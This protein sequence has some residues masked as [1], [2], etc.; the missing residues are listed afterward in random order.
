MPIL[1]GHKHIIWDWN[2]TLFDDAWLCVDIMNG[3][4]ARWDLPP[5]TPASYE[6][7]FDFPVRDYYRTIGWDFSIAPFETLSDEFISAYYRRMS[8]CPLRDGTLEVLEKGRRLGVS[9]SILSAM[10]ER[11][12]QPLVQRHGLRDCFTEIIGAD[13]HH[14]AGKLEKARAWMAGSG[15]NR[16][17]I[18][19]I[20]D[21]THDYDVARTLA[22]DCAL[23]HSGHHA[24]ARLAAA[25]VPI[26]ESLLEVF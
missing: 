12:L 8:E 5:V 6:A 16:A 11:Y 25:G 4:L 22:V 24:R 21:T 15:F 26:L 17:E 1:N 3:M 18:L 9:M 7:L 13:D 2:G 19:F 14:A 10:E 20:G 23:I